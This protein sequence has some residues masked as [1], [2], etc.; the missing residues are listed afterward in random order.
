MQLF[1]LNRNWEI[2]VHRLFY[3]QSISEGNCYLGIEN[4][5]GILRFL[6][7][8]WESFPNDKKATEN[9]LCSFM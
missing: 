6:M 9:I 4:I 7:D 2:K 5:R 1:S 8:Y 3:G